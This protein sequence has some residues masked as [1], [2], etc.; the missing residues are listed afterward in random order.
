MKA[1]KMQAMKRLCCILLIVIA[2]FSSFNSYGIADE[3]PHTVRVLLTN[4]KPGNQIQIQT[5]GLYTLDEVIFIQDGSVLNLYLVD[6][7]LMMHHQGLTYHGGQQIYL[8]RHREDLDEGKG[9]RFQSGSNLFAGDLKVSRQD[10]ALVL[11]MVLPIESYLLG[12]VP[13]EMAEDFPLEA[14]KA[15]AIAARTY[16]YSNLKPNQAYD[17]VDNTNDQVYRG[18][19][20]KKINAK[21]A[22]EETRGL[23][24]SFQGKLAYSFYTASNGGMTESAFN[25]WGR[26]QVPYLTVQADKYDLENPFSPVRTAQ[27]PKHPDLVENQLP[28]DLLTLLHSSIALRLRELELPAESGDYQIQEIKGLQAHTSKYGGES[29][30]MKTVRFDLLVRIK[31]GGK[32]SDDQE[33]SMER[34]DMKETTPS[35]HQIQGETWSSM[36]L[37]FDIPYFP[38]L[39][40]A[41]SLSINRNAN[42]LLRI[43][44]KE[45]HFTLKSTRYGHGVGLSQR[46]AEWMAKTY[47]WN[48][49]QIL[50]FYYPGTAIMEYQSAAVIP[51]TL[52]PFF[53]QTPGPTPTASPRPTLMPLTTDQSNTHQIVVV[54]G[55]ERDSSLNLR[56]TADYS[57]RIIMR[58]YYGQELIVI[59]EGDDGWLKVKSDVVEGFIRSEFVSPKHTE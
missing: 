58:L 14:L 40:Q 35:E 16:T 5:S 33:V 56:E 41:L 44:E 43:E 2:V 31:S 36:E 19:D 34:V 51:P 17:L 30:V 11:I 20:S 53:L 21:K 1:S 32:A 59:E 26:E 39:E 4:I 50:R 18:Y 27:L 47:G 45:D 7:Q 37:S 8:K 55:I 13:Y 25:A 9:L 15:Q 42:E 29:G 48:Y 22:I 10:G 57:S 49:E 24:N 52:K 28:P 38:E 54:D 3:N 46:G 12:V 23:V 6:D